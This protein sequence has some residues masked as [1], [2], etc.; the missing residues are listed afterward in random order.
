MAD[1]TPAPTEPKHLGLTL[2]EWAKI[3]MAPV[4]VAVIVGGLAHLT[5]EQ[6]PYLAFAVLFIV[7]VAFIHVGTQK[8]TVQS[9]ILATDN[10]PFE[11]S[12][13][14]NPRLTRI[15]VFVCLTSTCAAGLW[16]LLD[17]QL[18]PLASITNF[19]MSDIQY[20]YGQNYKGRIIAPKDFYE[21][22]DDDESILATPCVLLTVSIGQLRTRSV[23][24]QALEF[25]VKPIAFAYWRPRKGVY[26]H[27]AVVANR[28]SATV[29]ANSTS[30]KA[31]MLDDKG[32]PDVGTILLDDKQPF[33]LIHVQFDGTTG[34]YEVV[35]IVT[36]T[37]SFDRNRTKVRYGSNGVWPAVGILNSPDAEKLQRR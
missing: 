17:P 34:L 22:D 27:N 28:F 4:V 11:R 35:P 3:L 21:H 31:R 7:G 32:N 37:D 20:T 36:V 1:K 10:K 14:R 23:V 5:L 24:I 30:V 26:P 6:L 16:Y 12:T 2:G 9:D 18:V 33:A 13:P 8:V 15:G 19:E 29:T 25:E